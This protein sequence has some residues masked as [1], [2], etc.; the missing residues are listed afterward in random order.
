MKT[1]YNSL[2]DILK[3][4]FAKHQPVKKVNISH[5]QINDKLFS[6]IVSWIGSNSNVQQILMDDLSLVTY[7]VYQDLF[8]FFEMRNKKPPLLLIQ[9]PKSDFHRFIHSIGSDKTDEF[10]D[11]KRL[12]VEYHI[13]IRIHFN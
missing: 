8:K 9:F 4:V 5:N 12:F 11:E 1:D 13:S 3:A 6:K 7:G 10:L 2:N